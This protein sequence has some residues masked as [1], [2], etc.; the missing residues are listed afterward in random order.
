[1]VNLDEADQM[2]HDPEA[3]VKLAFK[4]KTNKTKQMKASPIDLSLPQQWDSTS[5][6]F[7]LEHNLG[8]CVGVLSMVFF[9]P[10]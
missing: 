9:M 6:P 7:C 2:S 8:D 5:P 4:S 1:M 10:P 3:R